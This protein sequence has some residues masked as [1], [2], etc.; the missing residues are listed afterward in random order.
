MIAKASAGLVTIAGNFAINFENRN[1]T[2]WM[3][4]WGLYYKNFTDS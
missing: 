3:V 1:M 2:L 4:M